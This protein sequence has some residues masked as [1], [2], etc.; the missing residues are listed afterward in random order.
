MT[1]EPLPRY[2]ALQLLGVSGACGCDRLN[3]VVYIGWKTAAGLLSDQSFQQGGPS[4]GFVMDS[5]QR[6]ILP[7]MM[8]WNHRTSFQPIAFLINGIHESGT[9]KH[10]NVFLNIKWYNTVNLVVERFEIS[11]IQMG[12][13]IRAVILLMRFILIFSWVKIKLDSKPNSFHRVLS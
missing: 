11:A 8:K 1:G 6:K 3:G 2:N 4:R 5:A 7:S 12:I 9:F 10:S 13:A